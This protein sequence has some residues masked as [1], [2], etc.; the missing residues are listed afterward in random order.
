MEQ[1]KF[2]LT[3]LVIAFV[4]AFPTHERVDQADHIEKMRQ[5]AF[6]LL[7]S[8][9]I[10]PFEPYSTISEKPFIVKLAEV[11]PVACEVVCKKFEK[12]VI[13]NK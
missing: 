12:S 8:S 5:L 1:N 7:E 10:H 2:G 9:Q 6:G 13:T 3:P 11:A 4:M